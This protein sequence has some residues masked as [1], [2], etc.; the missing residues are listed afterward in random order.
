MRHGLV[1]SQEQYEA[2]QRA[3]VK[4]R[5]ICHEDNETELQAAKRARTP[6]ERVKRRKVPV[7]RQSEAD[8]L[9]ECKD[10][11]ERHPKVALWWRQ[12]TGAVKIDERY[13]KF[14]FKGASDL[15]GMST[16]GRFVACECKATGKK[17]D[18]D[19]AAFLANVNKAGGLGVCCDHAGKLW[20]ALEAL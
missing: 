5:V 19:Q 15:M 18:D 20:L 16:R 17:A 8:V 12:N 3:V 9:D 1:M 6:Q 13:V 2:H 11:L 7:I 14:S 4:A 10:V